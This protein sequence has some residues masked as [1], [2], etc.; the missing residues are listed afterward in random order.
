MS[1]AFLPG[2]RLREE[3]IAKGMGVSR[4]PV[5]SAIQQLVTDG[6]ISFEE[7]RGAVVIGWTDRDVDDA[8]DIRCLLEPYASGAA[9]TYASVN[10][11]DELEKT[12]EEMWATIQSNRHDRIEQV[13]RLN[14]QF[15][16]ALIDAAHSAQIRAVLNGLV[17]M[18]ILIGSFYLYSIEDMQRSVEHH[19]QI[20]AALRS[21]NKQLAEVA[22]HY[23]LT[24]TRANYQTLRKQ[25]Q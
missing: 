2:Q 24:A 1:G 15:H 7:R 13:Q 5:R 25:H 6:L 20:I 8:F 4:T 10:E 9:A 22:M 17:D 12:N 3:H 16:N 11:I 18:P 19:R 14:N 23:H 21:R